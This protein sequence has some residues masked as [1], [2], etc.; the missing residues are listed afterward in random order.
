MHEELL[1][2][3]LSTGGEFRV[4]APYYWLKHLRSNT[5]LFLRNTPNFKS[6]ILPTHTS[7]RG[8][9]FRS[10]YCGK[11]G[12]RGHKTGR[13][14]RGRGLFFSPSPPSSSICLALA[15]P[16]STNSR[17]NTRR[18]TQYLQFVQ[19]TDVTYNKARDV[20]HVTPFI[21][22]FHYICRGSIVYTY[23]TITRPK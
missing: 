2:I 20:T 23:L 10:S 13:R 7:L 17:R 5:I 3:L 14:R 18:L 9:R 8:K 15:P 12:P 19:A 21:L 4:T 1:C 22:K 6:L 16:F 11:V